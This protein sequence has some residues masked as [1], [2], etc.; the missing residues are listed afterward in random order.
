MSL[1]LSQPACAALLGVCLRT[2]RHWDRGRNRVPW[3]AVRLLRILRGG[4]LPARG[5]DGWR[6]LDGGRLVTPA[7]VVFLAAEFEWWALT[8]LRARSWDREYA[9]QVSARLSA[10]DSARPAV[11]V[12]DG[13]VFEIGPA[14]AVDAADAGG[15]PEATPAP[16]DPPLSALVGKGD[17]SCGGARQRA[18][19]GLVSTAT[20]GTRQGESEAGCGSPGIDVGPE[21][22]H[23]GATLLEGS[24]VRNPQ[25]QPASAPGPAR[26]TARPGRARM[27]ERE[28]GHG[29]RAA[30]LDRVP[31][32][33]PSTGCNNGDAKACDNGHGAPHDCPNPPC[34]WPADQCPFV[35]CPR[36]EGRSESALPVR[37]RPEVQAL[38]RQGL[39][40][41]PPASLAAEPGTAVAS[42]H[43]RRQGR[44][45]MMP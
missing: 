45:G 14:R 10:G 19:A 26:G 4:E 43:N 30:K 17:G 21:W 1:N 29:G 28:R 7:G 2:V 24:H 42:D 23:N 16:A 25:A 8:C 13:G 15:E 22:G 32:P 9:R 6:V 11:P 40:V 36:R 35:V 44:Q 31:G 41:Q 34:D 3:S 5:W 39:K 33:A 37:Q 27:L 12:V 20:S 38:P 18:A